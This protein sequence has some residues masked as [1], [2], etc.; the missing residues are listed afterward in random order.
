M[1]VLD[2]QLISLPGA[3]VPGGALTLADGLHLVSYWK[4]VV[5]LIPLTFWAW[6]VSTSFDKFAARFY[7]KRERWNIIHLCFGLAALAAAL[8]IPV[9]G[10]GAF[11]AGLG[12]MVVILAIDVVWFIKSANADEKVPETLRLKLSKEILGRVSDGTR[13]KS[14][15]ATSTGKVEL[16][17]KGPDKATVP[18]PAAETPEL[19]T[20][21]AAEGLVLRSIVSRASQVDLSPTGKESLYGESLLVDGL[22]QAGQAI[23]AADAVRIIDFWK[24]AGGLDLSDRRKKLTA[25]VTV[26]KSELKKKIRVTTSGVQGGMRLSLVYDPERAVRRKPDDLGLDP[27]QMEELKAILDEKK[28]TVVV[29]TPPDGGRTTLLYTILKMHDAYTNNVQTVEIDQ[30]DDLEGVRQNRWDPYAEGPEFSTL[31][32]SILRRD[33]DIVGV[34]EVPD[35]NTAKEICRADLERSRI[36][37]SLRAD[38]AL[39]AIQAWS[40]VTGDLGTAMAGLRGVVAGR[41][42]RRLCTQCRQAY[43][44]APEMLKKFGLP[45]DRVKQLHKKGGVVLVKDKEQVCGMCAGVGYVGQVGFFEVYRIEDDLREMLKKGDWNAFRSELRKKQLPTLQGAALR[46]AIEGTTSVEEVVR[47]IAE[48]QP[49]AGAGAGTKAAAAPARTP[50]VVQKSS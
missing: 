15:E 2:S 6:L 4:P 36:Y 9:K 16:V 1:I 38:S 25:D 14:K 48:G 49:P 24:A 34:A 40:K 29:G 10:E 35:Q 21:V 28:G 13:K 5:L 31:V 26:E 8:F 41:V 47:A 22:R 27:R 44:P 17:I 11:W 18:V 32:R 33:P 46:H 50:D 12:A 3:A 19:A 37:V 23:P 45:S 42:M 39:G 20:R 30:Q 7:L 43:V